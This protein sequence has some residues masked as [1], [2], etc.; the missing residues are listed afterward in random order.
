MAKQLVDPWTLGPDGNPDP[1]TR[2]DWDMPDLPNLDEDNPQVDLVT[3]E[4]HDGLQP[5]VVVVEGGVVKQPP[6]PPVVVADPPPVETEGP[7]TME[8]EDGTVLTLEKEKGQWKGTTASAAGGNA[9]VYWGKTLKELIFNTLKAQANATKKIREQNTKLKFGQVAAKP[10]VPVPQPVANVR[11]LTADEIFEI[12]TQL[13]SDPNLA[14]Q[15][16]FQKTTGLSVQ[17]LVG[18]AQEGRQ[19]SLELRAEA[20]NREF[21]ARNPD[22]YGDTNFE[23]FA[24]LVKWVA[25]FKAGKVIHKGEETQTF[26]ELVSSGIWTVDN[27]EEAFEDLSNDDLLVKPPKQPRQAP[28]QV[29]TPP[30]VAVQQQEPAP[31]PRPDSRIVSQVTRPRAALGIGRNDVTPAV[32]PAAPKAP[33]AEDLESLSDEAVAQLLR[34]VQRERALSRR[35]N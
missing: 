4:Q 6:A 24:S 30:P 15:S 29:D 1:F 28:Q 26:N 10:A 21:I 27:L 34:G 8:L 20:V 31:A 22:Y 2:V 17:E 25:K 12:K 18:S 32:E 7:E 3:L 19:A 5:E 33:S 14:L 16:W 13:D 11:T 9:Q 35:S 23:N